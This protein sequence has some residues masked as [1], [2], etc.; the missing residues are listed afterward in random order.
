M[1]VDCR[2]HYATLCCEAPENETGARYERLKTSYPV[3]FTEYCRGTQN[4]NDRILE[5]P[6]KVRNHLYEVLGQWVPIYADIRRYEFQTPGEPGAFWISIL[7]DLP[8]GS[9]WIGT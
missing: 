8:S 1:C 7:V 3:I 9:G 5:L 2:A 4:V 6:Q